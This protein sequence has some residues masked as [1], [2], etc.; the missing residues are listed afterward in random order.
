MPF[1]L[2]NETDNGLKIIKNQLF[3]D[4]RGYFT[5]SYNKRDFKEIGIDEEFVQDNHSVSQKGVLRG[6]HFQ[7]EP[8]LGKLIRVTRGAARFI[9]LDI[10]KGSSHF[11]KYHTFE[12]SAEK[13]YML[14]VPAGFANGFIALEDDTHVQYKCTA[15]W[16]PKAEAS[17]RW[18]DP[19]LSIDWKLPIGFEPL[20]SEKDKNGITLKN[21]SAMPESDIL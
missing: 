12:L 4:D 3:Q 13:G 1:K 7:W 14:W 8:K 15:L 19:E 21:W 18:N 20:V 2:Q 16:N 11:A 10:R 6:L 9:E 5:E 17:I